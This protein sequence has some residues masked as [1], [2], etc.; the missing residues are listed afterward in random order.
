MKKT[1]YINLC[2]VITRLKTFT[3]VSLFPTRYLI[4]AAHCQKTIK[5]R[6]YANIRIL[7]GTNGIP[8]AGSLADLYEIVDLK[9]HPMSVLL[10]FCNAFHD[11]SSINSDDPCSILRYKPSTEEYDIGLIK[12]KNKVTFTDKISPVCLTQRGSPFL[13][14]MATVA[15]W[16]SIKYGDTPPDTLREVDVTFFTQYKYI[17]V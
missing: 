17:Y 6:G 11:W 12:L 2:R 14:R 7:M 8:G 9:T 3:L 1:I 5:K 10:Q 15:G 13:D 16:G 4:T